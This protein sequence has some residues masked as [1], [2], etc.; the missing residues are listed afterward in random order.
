M[1]KERMLLFFIPYSQVTLKGDEE[2]EEEDFFLSLFI[3]S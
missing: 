3:R 1:K 2:E